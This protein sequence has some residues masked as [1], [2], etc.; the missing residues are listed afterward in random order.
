MAS[1]HPRL[2]FRCRQTVHDF[3]HTMFGLGRDV[4][5]RPLLV[6]ARGVHV[7]ETCLP[8]SRLVNPVPRV[9]N[10]R[11]LG[12]TQHSSNWIPASFSGQGCSL[13]WNFGGNAKAHSP[14]R[15]YC[16]ASKNTAPTFAPVFM[17]MPILFN[18]HASSA[19]RHAHMLVTYC[20]LA[21]A[22]SRISRSQ[23]AI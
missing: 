8:P 6:R 21:P 2:P 9:H 19:S 12:K 15:S 1:L 14:L 5:V 20:S 22:S 4:L 10:Y 7:L 13:M 23:A 11:I 18:G 3:D 17:A 16:S